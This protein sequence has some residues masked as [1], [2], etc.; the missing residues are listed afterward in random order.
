MIGEPVDKPVKTSLVHCI[1]PLVEEL[2]G[3]GQDLGHSAGLQFAQLYQNGAVGNLQAE[4]V[5]Q[6]EYL[7]KHHLHNDVLQGDFVLER[8]AE[9]LGGALFPL[10]EVGHEDVAQLFLDEPALD[11]VLARKD[12]TLGT[13]GVVEHPET[14]MNHLFY[15]SVAE[16]KLFIFGSGSYSAPPS[17]II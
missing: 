8:I 2:R 4:R 1:N 17:S 14:K 11:A 5:G 13:I 12:G 6:T 3:L 15:T 16:P 7:A 10:L 9:Q